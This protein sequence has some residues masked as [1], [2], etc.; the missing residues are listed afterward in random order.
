M[1]PTFVAEFTKGNCNLEAPV[2]PFT[3]KLWKMPTEVLYQVPLGAPAMV[4]KPPVQLPPLFATK[5]EQG[6]APGPEAGAAGQ[7]LPAVGM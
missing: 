3:M 2:S 5:S 7:P 6:P 1:A 4:G